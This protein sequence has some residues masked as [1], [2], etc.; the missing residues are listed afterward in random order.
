VVVDGR[1]ERASLRPAA[2]AAVILLDTHAMIWL[3]A[4]HRRARP[5][6]RFSRIYISPVGLLEV[7]FLLEAG[8]LALVS[9]RSIDALAEDAR[10]VLDEPPS[11]R[12]FTAACATSWT[13][14]PFD[15][16]LAAHA[17]VRGWRLAT[18]DE[19][20]IDRLGSSQTLSL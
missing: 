20:L 13:R 14:D 16:L 10:W 17:A 11:G 18:A 2:E 6:D 12:W 15:R 3:A 7:Q 5:L 9:G 8:R 19:I 1:A 4:G